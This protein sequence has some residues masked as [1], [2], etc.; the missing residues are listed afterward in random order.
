VLNEP[1]GTVP[2]VCAPQ[3]YLKPEVERRIRNRL[4]RLEGQVRGVERLLAAHHSCDDLLVQLGA[5]KQAVTGVI[6][7][8]L[9]GHMQ[10]CVAESVERGQGMKALAS[11]R[12]AL[13]S[14]LRHAS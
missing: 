10:T 9:E 5:I 4:K 11:L 1:G 14:A 8:L 7:E 12:G 13:A 6:V 3:V 2:Q